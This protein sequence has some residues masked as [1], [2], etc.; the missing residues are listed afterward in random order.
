MKPE[1]Q[2]SICHL[3]SCSSLAVSVAASLCH[4]SWPCS[5]SA[6][7]K[8]LVLMS[9]A[10]HPWPGFGLMLID[11]GDAGAQGD[12]WQNQKSPLLWD[13]SCAASPTLP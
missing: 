10:L 8:A 1:H 2:Q 5:N 3:A 13:S 9:M 12:S 7:L 6:S 4:V 11:S